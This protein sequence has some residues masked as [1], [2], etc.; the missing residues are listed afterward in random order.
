MRPHHPMH[1]FPMKMSHRKRIVK[2]LTWAEGAVD[3]CLFECGVIDVDAY[4]PISDNNDVFATV[5]P[6][7]RSLNAAMKH[8]KKLT[9]AYFKQ[10]QQKKLQSET[11]KMKNK[12]KRK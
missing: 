1:S 3:S 2:M 10:K 4:G 9:D 7:Y 11:K 8:T 5:I 12:K 6:K